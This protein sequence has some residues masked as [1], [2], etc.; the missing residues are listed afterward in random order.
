VSWLLLRRALD[1]IY[2]LKGNSKAGTFHVDSDLG[3]VCCDL[4]RWPGVPVGSSLPDSVPEGWLVAL[5]E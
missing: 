1:S 3:G 5:V 2:L 4:E